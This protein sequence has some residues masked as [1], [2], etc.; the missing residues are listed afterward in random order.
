[1]N[2]QKISYSGFIIIAGII[3][4]IGLFFL[5]DTDRSPTYAPVDV[6]GGEIRVSDQ[7]L[8]DIVS[9]SVDLSAPGFISIHKSIGE[10]PG[11]VIG[12]S[13][14]LIVGSYGGIIIVLQEMMTEGET[15]IALLHVDDGDGLFDIQKDLPVQVNGEVVRPSFMA[16]PQE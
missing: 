16:L 8:I 3:I 1:M 11:K 4:I 15:Y 12:V 13:N 10:A 2:M 6:G 7:K 9:L 14:Y 5:T